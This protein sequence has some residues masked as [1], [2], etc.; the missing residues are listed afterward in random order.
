[1]SQYNEQVAVD[2]EY[3][4][5]ALASILQPIIERII[6]LVVKLLQYINYIAQA[7]FNVNLFSNASTDSFNK[8]RGSTKQMAKDTKEMSKNLAG[9]IDEITNLNI[10]D[11]S[12]NNSGDNGATGI[13]SPSFDLSGLDGDVP[14]WLQWIVNNKDIILSVLAGIASGLLAWKLGL[15]PIK[16]LG[17]GIAIAGIVYAIQ[18]LLDYLK[19]P[20]WE[21]FGK[22]ITGIGVAVAGVALAFIGW[23]AALVGVAIAIVGIIISYWEQIKSFLQGGIDWLKTKGREIFVWLFGETFAPLYDGFVNILQSILHYF[24]T[25]FTNIKAIFDNLIDFIKNIFTGNWQGAWENI[26]NIF[27]ILIDQIKAHFIKVFN[28][29]GNLV[30][31]VGQTVGNV[32]A[33]V[34]KTVVNAVLGA[35]ESILNSPIRAVNKLIKVI[36]D[37]PGI[38]LG[39]L[40]TFKLPR[41][42][43][44]GIVNQPGKGVNMG[45]Y[46]AGERGAEA[47]IPLQNSKFISDFANQIASQMGN[48]LNTEL[49]L[50]LN[51]NISDLANRPINFYI[52]GKDCAQALYNDLKNEENRLNA[53]NSIVLK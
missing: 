46:I 43:K 44:G 20:S 26:K 39:T 47:I 4:N 22:V 37:V 40:P 19:D 9:G 7:W 21:N 49:L 1:M 33:G 50:E 18:G 16:S 24:D 6:N 14:G 52:N 10:Q 41:L 53:S 36:N 8:A 5:F 51:R 45:N 32:I 27:F 23:P 25:T 28:I 31:G 3:I 2:L 29:L 13:T 15:K 17:I 38:N 48:D 12:T 35:I 34:F 11:N 42:A 30:V